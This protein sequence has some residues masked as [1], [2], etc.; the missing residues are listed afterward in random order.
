MVFVEE[1]GILLMKKSKLNIGKIMIKNI[2]KSNN[3]SDVDIVKNGYFKKTIAMSF[4]LFYGI[5]EEDKK[6]FEKDIQN[7]VKE[8]GYECTCKLTDYNYNSYSRVEVKI[9][10]NDDRKDLTPLLSDLDF[11]INVIFLMNDY[12]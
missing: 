9:N 1:Y 12:Y 6:R 2:H 5:Y 3:I 8:L 7:Y 10:C 4:D 11:G